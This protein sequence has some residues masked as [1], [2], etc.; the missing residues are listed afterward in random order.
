MRSGRWDANR[1]LGTV[2]TGMN[3]LKFQSNHEE[4]TTMKSRLIAILV[5]LALSLAVANAAL[6]DIHATPGDND[7]AADNDG[8]VKQVKHPVRHPAPPVREQVRRVR[9]RIAL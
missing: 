3:G 8:D 5:L 2:K 7:Q 6:A 4:E 1:H 9:D